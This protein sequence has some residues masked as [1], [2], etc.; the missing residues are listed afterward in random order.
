MGGITVVGLRSKRV[1]IHVPEH[2]VHRWNTRV[3][4]PG[5]PA[6][7][8]DR[9]REAVRVAMSSTSRVVLRRGQNGEQSFALT[10]FRH[11]A[12]VIIQP[13][14]RGWRLMTCWSLNTRHSH[15][16]EAAAPAVEEVE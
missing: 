6:W 12:K 2:F 11:H 3:V 16:T 4:G 15:P 5:K 13:T 8:E 7:S 9:I 14:M 10:L 1:C